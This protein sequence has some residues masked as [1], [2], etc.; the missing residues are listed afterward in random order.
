MSYIIILITA[1][2]LS[3]PIHAQLKVSSLV[4]R[5]DSYSKYTEDMVEAMKLAI[6]VEDM[7]KQVLFRNYFHNGT[8]EDINRNCELIKKDGVDVV[9]GGET[10]QFAMIIA[11]HFNDKVFISPTA[12]S[13]LLNSVHPFP[14]RMIHSDE[15]YAKLATFVVRDQSLKS[16]GVFHNKSYPNTD[17]IAK[18]TIENLRSLK[19]KVSV[20]EYI[21]G[22]DITS[23]LL[24][25]FIKQKVDSVMVFTYE[26]DLRKI[27]SGLKE[28]GLSPLYVGADG[29][30]RDEF[31][32]RNLLSKSQD[33]K[34]IRSLY[35]NS[36][37]KDE[38]F[39]KLVSKLETHLKKSMDAFFAIG[40]DTMK[41]VVE[42]YKL[43]PKIKEFNS[44]ILSNTFTGFL[45]S[46][47]LSYDKGLLPI[48]DFYL[49]KL[50]HGKI[51]F[52]GEY[53]EQR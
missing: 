2:V 46:K 35:W 23:E 42:V 32:L 52:Y 51:E 37:R 24:S 28:S 48:K 12:S 8:I 9:I 36:H 20:V 31:L 22:Q 7:K 25:P 4:K 26:N 19:I 10:S 14:I 41:L 15:Q 33:F 39:L 18:K 44:T 29:W 50:G 47:N 43:N 38:Y 45:T 5:G 34:G 49:F 21:N 30:G 6:E 1:L 53:N 40:F 27:Y 17:L 13:S 3:F 11:K 16:V